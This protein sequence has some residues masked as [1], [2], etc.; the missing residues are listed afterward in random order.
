[1]TMAD[2]NHKLYRSRDKRMIAGVC[3]GLGEYIGVDPTIVRL[4]FALG[5]FLGTL[6]FWVYLVMMLVIPEEP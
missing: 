3:G 1:M 2:D 4:L 6:T 5:L